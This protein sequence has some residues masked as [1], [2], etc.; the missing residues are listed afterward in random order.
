MAKHSFCCE[1]RVNGLR[2]SAP[3]TFRRYRCRIR[4]IAGRPDF[5]ASDVRRMLDVGKGLHL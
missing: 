1:L 2:V 4:R 3:F 5:E